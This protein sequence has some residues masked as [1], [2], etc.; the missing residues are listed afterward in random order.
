MTDSKP[1]WLGED[2]AEGV[3][4]QARPDLVS[5]PH[6]RLEAVAAT[7]RPRSLAI[8]RDGRTAIFV[9]D[10]DTSDVW[11]LDLDERVPRRV[12]CAPGLSPSLAC[13]QSAAG[14]ACAGFIA[15]W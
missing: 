14:T 6:W 15:R 11:S 1:L 4:S 8:G 3:P 5:P 7:E 9:Q 13:P 2:E 10:R 12:K